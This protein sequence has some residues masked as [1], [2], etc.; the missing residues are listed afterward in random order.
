MNDRNTGNPGG[1]RHRKRTTIPTE[2]LRELGESDL[3]LD[4]I[5]LEI[6]KITGEPP[7]SR[8]TVS[9]WL[10]KLDLARNLSHAHLTPW[11]NI[12][13]EH[14]GQRWQEMLNSVGRILDLPR[15]RKPS[16]TDQRNY[17]IFFDY[18][19]PGYGRRRMVCGYHEDI[20]WYLTD[21]TDEEIEAGEIIRRPK[22]NGNGGAIAS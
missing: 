12:R 21:A 19:D 18:I 17:D 16:I 22:T 8:G 13:P 7:V 10:S 3:T 1:R 5:A 11:R 4:G 6:A 20:G 14:T 2:V 9:K 15:G